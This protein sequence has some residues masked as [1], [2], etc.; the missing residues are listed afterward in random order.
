M[1]LEGAKLPAQRYKTKLFTGAT[2][3]SDINTWV[4]TNP[5]P[6]VEFYM[7]HDGTNPVVMVL[8]CPSP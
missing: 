4:D 5:G 3:E 2:V 1:P 7:T 6:L 8:Y